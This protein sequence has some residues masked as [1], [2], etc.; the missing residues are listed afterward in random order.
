MIN[1]FVPLTHAALAEFMPQGVWSGSMSGQGDGVVVPL[2]EAPLFGLGRP[3]DVRCS[4]GTVRVCQ[5]LGAPLA[6]APAPTPAAPATAPRAPAAPAPAPS[7]D[8][9][10]S[11]L[12]EVVVVGTS[13]WR[14]TLTR[15]LELLSLSAQRVVHVRETRNE[16]V[17]IGRLYKR[18]LYVSFGVWLSPFAH[19]EPCMRWADISF[20]SE[21]VNRT[22]VGIFC[23]EAGVTKAPPGKFL[24]DRTGQRVGWLSADGGYLYLFMA[25]QNRELAEDG[26]TLMRAVFSGILQD[27]IPQFCDPQEAILAELGQILEDY[28]SRERGRRDTALRAL[29]ADR[30]RD[31]IRQ[32]AEAERHLQSCRTALESA[33]STLKL[34]EEAIR[35]FD[36]IDHLTEIKKGLEVLHRD[37][38][39][40]DVELCT[41]MSVHVRTKTVEV[42]H[43]GKTYI[44]GEYRLVVPMSSTDRIRAFR[45]GGPVGSH[46]HPHINI[47]GDLCMGNLHELIRP[48]RVG[49]H[50]APTVEALIDF[51]HSVW[52]GGWYTSI[53]RWPVKEV[54]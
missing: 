32:H 51:L 43:S 18:R 10:D 45:I 48:F 30:K 17:E 28:R 37:A 19:D 24:T 23:D 20:Q 8:D 1:I 4:D 52:P 25:P 34:R 50:L 9:A 5:L 42:A 12:P 21:T 49:G 16:P 27:I 26:R 14:R 29:I 13:D 39:I 40:V 3:N 36:S 11:S 41:D 6:G 22:P 47:H 38:R 53:E 33:V 35:Q 15:P 31:I 46:H 7:S 2:E 54:A 44:L